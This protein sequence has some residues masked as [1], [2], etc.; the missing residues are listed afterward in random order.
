LH[1]NF[2]PTRCRIR[3]IVGVETPGLVASEGAQG[4]TWLI[5]LSIAF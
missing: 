3:T 1:E 5:F 2:G 4:F